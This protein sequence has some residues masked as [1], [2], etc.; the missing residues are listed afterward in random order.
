LAFNFLLDCANKRISD[1]IEV[2]WNGELHNQ[3]NQDI[4]SII[5]ALMN[6]QKIIEHAGEDDDDDEEDDD[7]KD[8]DE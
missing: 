6:E 5:V 8:D 7:D 1:V 3:M 4:F 2:N